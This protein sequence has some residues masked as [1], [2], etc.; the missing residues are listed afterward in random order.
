MT[1]ITPNN[2]PFPAY[3]ATNEESFAYDTTK[4]RWPIILENAIRD[5]KTSVAEQQGNKTRCEQANTIIKYLEDM[6]QEISVDKALRYKKHITPFFIYSV[7]NKSL[8]LLE[9]RVLIQKNGTT[10]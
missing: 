3:R 4:R 2:P 1:D 8:D 7:L 10:T 9:I 6:I 5:I